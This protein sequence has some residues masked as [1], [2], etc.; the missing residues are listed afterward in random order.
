[1]QG[2][3]NREQNPRAALGGYAEVRTALNEVKGNTV[4]YGR[5][6]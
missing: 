5:F 6:A 1:M 3:T 2:Q 4:G